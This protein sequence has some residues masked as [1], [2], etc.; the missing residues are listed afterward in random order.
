MSFYHKHVNN[1]SLAETVE[2]D[3]RRGSSRNFS[4]TVNLLR[5]LQKVVKNNPSKILAMVQWKSFAVFKR[6]L[7]IN[8]E[9][10][11]LYS[12][13]LLK[14]QIPFLGKKWRISISVL[15]YDN[16]HIISLIY[17]H[18]RPR[19]KDETLSCDI[20]TD[21]FDLL[22][23]T[24]ALTNQI[25]LYLQDFKRLSKKEKLIID[26]EDKDFSNYENWLSSEVLLDSAFES[27][28]SLWDPLEF[29]EPLTDDITVSNIDIGEEDLST[30][31]NDNESDIDEFTEGWTDGLK[32]I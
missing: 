19:L 13:K 14:C 11:H 8:N 31:I 22:Q 10:L 21:G 17:L 12:L 4:T 23:S 9:D 3:I 30:Y 24:N 5:I 32:F 28:K 15:T 20:E 27:A 18:V 29:S 25:Q 16:T 26:D 7:R 2:T 1:T 6:I